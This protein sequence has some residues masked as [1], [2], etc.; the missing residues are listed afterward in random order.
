MK[1]PN[2]LGRSQLKS[3][4][5]DYNPR[6]YDTKKEERELRKK[7]REQSVE[8]SKIRI[9]KSFQQ[10][11]DQA[12]FRKSMS[13]QRNMRIIGIVFI[14]LVVFYFLIKEFLP[15]LLESLSI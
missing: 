13:R 3:R 4:K 2:I 1:L 8:G 9:A 15:L 7:E 11:K 5:F 14:L 10:S 6:Y 12:A